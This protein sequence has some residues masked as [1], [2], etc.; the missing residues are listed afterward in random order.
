[1]RPILF[2]IGHFS[3]RANIVFIL[4]AFFLGSYLAS[5]EAK[6][7][8]L[9][10]KSISDF[11]YWALIAGLIGGRLSYVV[12]SGFFTY[13]I[14][15]PVRLIPSLETGSTFYGLIAGVVL[16]AWLFSQRHKEPLLR[17]LDALTPGLL[18]SQ[19][20]G[21]IGNFLMGDAYG[22]PTNV[23]WGVVFP[24]GSPIHLN[25]LREGIIPFGAT[26]VPVHPTQIYELVLAL[27]ILLLV[28]ILRN[29]FKRN[30]LL[31]LFYLSLYSGLRFFLEFLRGDSL[32]FGGIPLAYI[33]SILIFFASIGL[34]LYLRL[35]STEKKL[36]P[37]KVR[38]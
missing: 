9:D 38:H 21:Q 8:G 31:F 5:S 32:E 7:R 3:F 30:G 23:P 14:K 37:A 22:K 2:N 24:V 17:F 19:S 15:N 16:A 33:S 10:L 12:F 36:S 34:F 28:W 25:Q 29:R 20:I 26:P 18:L 27:G 1:M 13:Y 4:I 6:K 11:S 35:W